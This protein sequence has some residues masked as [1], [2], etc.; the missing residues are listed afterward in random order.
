VPGGSHVS[1]AVGSTTPS[2]QPAQSESLPA[3]HPTGQ[4]LSLPALEQ[5]FGAEVQT[6]LHVAAVPVC[7][8]VVQSF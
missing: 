8:S 2:P 7:V 4:H 5:V 6:T 1:P 3:V